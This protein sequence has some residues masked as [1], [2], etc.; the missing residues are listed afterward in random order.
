V[1]KN[2]DGRISFEE[3]LVAMKGVELKKK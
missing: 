2:G 1:D 3:W